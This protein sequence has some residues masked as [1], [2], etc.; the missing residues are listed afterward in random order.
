MT[1]KAQTREEHAQIEAEIREKSRKTTTRFLTQLPAYLGLVVF[2]L[3]Y[4]FLMLVVTM[5]GMV[6]VTQFV[7]MLTRS[8][9]SEA[10]TEMTMGVFLNLAFFPS[11]AITLALV[12]IYLMLV[13]AGWRY[14]WSRG[15]RPTVV[16]YRR[17]FFTVKDK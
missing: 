12:G 6:L 16:A 8:L 7:T 2:S 5:M 14:S 1:K 4:W 9:G 3:S 10:V 13:R 15:Y 17:R 11:L